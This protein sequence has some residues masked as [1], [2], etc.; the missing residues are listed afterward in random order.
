VVTHRLARKQAPGRACARL[1]ARPPSDLQQPARTPARPRTRLPGVVGSLQAPTR[2]KRAPDG[3]KRL[4]IAGEGLAIPRSLDTVRSHDLPIFEP[5]STP[6]GCQC[7]SDPTPGSS[8]E[9]SGYA[10]KQL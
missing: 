9:R 8:L 4:Y 6:A 1:R 10:L 2:V 3:R 5:V 7:S